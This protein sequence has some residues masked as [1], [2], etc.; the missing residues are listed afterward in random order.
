MTKRYA[1]I[2]IV[3]FEFAEDAA[4]PGYMPTI[5]TKGRVPASSDG[6]T[7]RW[8]GCC[9]EIAKYLSLAREAMDPPH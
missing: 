4:I 2:Q 1:Y 7:G 6:E 8:F 3:E 9:L 5:L